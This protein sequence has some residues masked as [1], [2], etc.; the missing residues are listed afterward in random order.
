MIRT[1]DICSVA[2][3][4]MTPTEFDNSNYVNHYISYLLTEPLW[5]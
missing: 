1:I 2:E 5:F 4:I 3:V